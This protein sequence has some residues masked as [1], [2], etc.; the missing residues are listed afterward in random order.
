MAASPAPAAAAALLVLLALAAASGVAADSSDHRYKMNE[1][2]SLY[3]N[4]VGPFH[5]PR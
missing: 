2:V 3:A 4:K 5:N 1:P